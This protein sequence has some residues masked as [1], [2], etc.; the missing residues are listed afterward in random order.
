MHRLFISHIQKYPVNVNFIHYENNEKRERILPFILWIIKKQLK[1]GK[2]NISCSNHEDDMR[3]IVH[4]LRSCDTTRLHHCGVLRGLYPA[5]SFLLSWHHNGLPCNGVTRD[6]ARSERESAIALGI[7]TEVMEKEDNVSIMDLQR[8][9]IEEAPSLTSLKIRFIS[10]DDHLLVFPN[11]KQLHLSNKLNKDDKTDRWAPVTH[12]I[13]EQPS[14]T[15]LTL[16]R[17]D[18]NSHDIVQINSNTL[19]HL[20][21]TGCGKKFWIEKCECPSLE[22]L[23]C[24]GS[25]YGNGIRCKLPSTVEDSDTFMEISHVGSRQVL[26]KD[27]KCEDI[28]IPN[29]CMITFQ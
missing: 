19:K 20:D 23:I 3:I 28:S 15:H 11:V 5:N 27:F 1:L 2:I 7:P 14:L 17:S 18:Y 4:L 21:V 24:E 22:S 13:Y 26:Y 6:L 10:S 25:C 29:T 9:L 8:V 12:A 16:A